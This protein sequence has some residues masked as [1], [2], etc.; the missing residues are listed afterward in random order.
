METVYCLIVFSREIKKN[1]QTN[2]G[3][4]TKCKEI[5][6]RQIREGEVKKNE[7]ALSI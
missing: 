3:D 5:T 1:A 7:N 2:L 4:E 6:S